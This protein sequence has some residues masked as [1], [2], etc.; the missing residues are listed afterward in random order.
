M[1]ILAN[2]LVQNNA[3]WMPMFKHMFSNLER[4][5]ELYIYENNSTDGTKECLFGKKIISENIIVPN[6][7]RT[8]RI[9]HFRNKLKK[10]VL[11]ENHEYVL[12]IDS[13]IFFSKKTLDMMI[14]TLENNP[15]VAMVCPHGMVKTSLPCEFFYD[16]FATVLLDGTRCGQFTSVIECK[17]NHHK[18]D[19]HCHKV[20]DTKPIFKQSS[21]LKEVK[22]SFGGFVLLRYSAFKDSWW[23]TNTPNDCEHWA[24]CEQV[25]KHGKIVINTEAKVIWTEF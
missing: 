20:T 8:E 23:S 21:E 6:W 11:P 18:H 16:T 22:S 4:D 15:D 1:K 12:L 3:K 10:C 13:N 9:S 14:E 24:F 2:I 5:I 17:S 7:S 25:R 19:R